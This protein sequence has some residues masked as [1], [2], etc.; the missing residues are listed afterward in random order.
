MS[1]LDIDID[2]ADRTTALEHLRHRFAR[3]ITERQ[4]GL[5][6]KPL[7]GV[8]NEL[9][10][11][12]R[13]IK[14]KKDFIP[15]CGDTI[16]VHVLGASWKKERGRDQLVPTTVY[17]T[18]FIGFLAPDSPFDQWTN[19]P[20]KPHYVILSASSH[21][22]QAALDRKR[23]CELNSNIMSAEQLEFTSARHVAGEVFYGDFKR[24]KA[25]GQGLDVW[26][27][28]ACPFT[29][30]LSREL[31]G[32]ATV[33]WIIFKEP[34]V[35]EIVGAGFQKER[36]CRPM[37][38]LDGQY[39]ALRWPRITKVDRIDGDPVDLMQLQLI[40]ERAMISP[41]A[42]NETFLSHVS[43][44]GD[45]PD[46]NSS[47]NS[48]LARAKA[49]ECKKW[50][51]K[52]EQADK[53]ERSTFGRDNKLADGETEE[54]QAR[55]IAATY[56][57]VCK[58]LGITCINQTTPGSGSR[59]RSYN[60]LGT[61]N[62][63]DPSASCRSQPFLTDRTT[64]GQVTDRQSNSAKLLPPPSPVRTLAPLAPLKV[65]RASSLVSEVQ[66]ESSGF[67]SLDFA[68]S[69]L[70]APEIDSPTGLPGPCHLKCS[71]YYR[72]PLHV[73]WAAGWS[74]PGYR[75]LS[76]LRQGVIYVESEQDIDFVRQISRHAVPSKD[77]RLLWF[78]DRR[79][80]GQ[81]TSLQSL[82]QSNKVLQVW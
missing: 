12:R 13:W 30:S 7:T 35:F 57:L 6:L 28:D 22:F 69:I 51:A 2:F 29:F 52:L 79:F 8:Y 5:M 17:T 78:I 48:M 18:F 20:A 39:H 10:D 9:S 80:F 81:R 55:A 72:H 74:I 76:S 70:P 37:L 68:W 59:K 11:N 3:I 40:A 65:L 60:T 31:E 36:G 23:L 26:M 58:A 42:V 32:I 47:L 44:W 43:R 27:A 67:P 82:S 46:H 45:Q 21:G 25:S 49:L 71:N 38:L 24:V 19:Q 15:G 56:A 50:V 53:M 73:L 63:V 75:P 66:S 16:D 61:D 54:P 41:W 34:R 1:L 33:P 64:R 4:E 77:K 14:L 62:T